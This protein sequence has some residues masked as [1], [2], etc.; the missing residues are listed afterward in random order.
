M[1]TCLV[2]DD[3]RVIRKVARR[4][5]ENLSF[6]VSEA[7]DGLEALKAC[8]EKMP[9]AIL[10]DWNMPV[11]DGITFLRALRQE[12]GGEAPKVV[13]CT[14]ENDFDHISQ[15]MLAGANEY[16]MKPFDKGILE[17]KLAAAG[18]L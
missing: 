8:K 3:S 11:M 15:A 7:N 14:T 17:A 13:F 2:V 16:V 12:P 4:I 1:K 18:V 6:E 9:S 5:L 10:L